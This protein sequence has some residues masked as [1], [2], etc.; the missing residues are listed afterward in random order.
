[1]SSGPNSLPVHSRFLVYFLR[2]SSLMTFFHFEIYNHLTTGDQG[3]THKLKP[4]SFI[5]VVLYSNVFYL[6]PESS[7]GVYIITK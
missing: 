5:K 2:T 3:T 4:R 1:M 7:F 6:L